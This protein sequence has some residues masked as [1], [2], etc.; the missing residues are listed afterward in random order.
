MR[1]AKINLRRWLSGLA[2]AALAGTVALNVL[3]WRHAYAM[4]HFGRGFVKTQVPEKLTF[5]EKAQVL[6]SGV[7][8][9]RPET[10]IPPAS[11]GPECRAITIPCTNGITLGAWYCPVASSSSLVL[12]FH[13]Y[14]GEKTGTMPE[15]KAFLELGASVLLVDFRGSGESSE[16]MTTIGFLEAEDVA[17]AVRYARDRL[18]NAKII[19]YGQ[20]MGAAAVLRAVHSCGVTPDAVVIESVFD[21]LLNTVRHRFEAMGAPAFPG[22]Q[23]LAF[24]G[25]RQ[26][27]FNAFE[28]NPV[29][30]AASLRCPSL[31]LHGSD[32]PRARIDEARRVFAAAP[33]KKVFLE[34]PGLGHQTGIA[35]FPTEWKQAVGQLLKE[36]AAGH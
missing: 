17:A 1:V 28:H 35:R 25:G 34:F 19:L 15:A 31:F 36:A 6:V 21:S 7:R 8:L 22:A 26:T 13:G 20:S 29:D 24:W 33:G 23:L 3:A 27:G 16:A 9:P 11:L 32:D 12:L 5:F 14:A 4:T 30:Y 2:A 18:G 10:K